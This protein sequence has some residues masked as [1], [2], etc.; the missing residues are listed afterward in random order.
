M[1]FPTMLLTFM[2]YTACSETEH[3]YCIS[4]STKL[5]PFGEERF[6]SIAS[7]RDKM[8]FLFCSVSEAK[9]SVFGLIRRGPPYLL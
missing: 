9:N 4:C 3:G 8:V 7:L 5:L 6:S 1:I 2:L